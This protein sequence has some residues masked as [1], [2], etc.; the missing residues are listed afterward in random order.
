MRPLSAT[1]VLLSIVPNCCSVL[2]TTVTL[3]RAAL[4]RP[5]RVTLP[6]YGSKVERGL[7]TAPT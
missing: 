7:A 6:A 3:A 4:T 1:E 2:P 5:S